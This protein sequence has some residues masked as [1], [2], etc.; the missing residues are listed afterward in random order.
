MSV[1]DKKAQNIFHKSQF[2]HYFFAAGKSYHYYNFVDTRQF[3]NVTEILSITEIGSYI[4][5]HGDSCLYKC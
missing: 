2:F 4:A 3:L 1:Y 5:C